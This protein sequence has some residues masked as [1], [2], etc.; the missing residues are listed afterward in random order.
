M[1]VEELDALAQLALQV[2]VLGFTVGT[3]AGLVR[4]SV[5]PL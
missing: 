1:T 5:K 4:R 2:F 3:L